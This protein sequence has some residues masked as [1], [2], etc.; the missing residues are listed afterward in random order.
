[1]QWCARPKSLIHRKSDN[2]YWTAGHPGHPAFTG[3][4]FFR[5]HRSAIGWWVDRS[6]VWSFHTWPRDAEVIRSCSRVRQG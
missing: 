3:W 2:T 5:L 6:D 1:M 4:W